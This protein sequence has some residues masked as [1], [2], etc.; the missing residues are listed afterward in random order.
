MKMNRLLGHHTMPASTFEFFML[1][2][3]MSCIPIVGPIM[4]SM[5]TRKNTG[6]PVSMLVVSLNKRNMEGCQCQSVHIPFC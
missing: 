3:T 2:H 4:Q 1:A 6:S 5:G